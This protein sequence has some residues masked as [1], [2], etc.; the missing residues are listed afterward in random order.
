MGNSDR[1]KKGEAYEGLSFFDSDD[2]RASLE[3]A[4]EQAALAAA[5]DLGDR[6]NDDEVEFEVR[7][8]VSARTHNQ[9]VKAYKVTITP[10]G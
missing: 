7:I 3:E 5:E 4:F 8:A 10:G 9:H 2:N 1:R 6:V